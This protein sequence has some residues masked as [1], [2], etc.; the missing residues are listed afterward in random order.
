MQGFFSKLQTASIVRPDGRKVSC[1]S[2][3][4]YKNPH[5]PKMTPYGNFEKGIM[6]IGEYPSETDDVRGK[7]FQGKGGRLLKET[8]A[9][10]GFDLFN[11][12]VSL[13]AINCRPLGKDGKLAKVKPFEIECC[14]RIVLA[15][16]NKYK[17]KVIILLGGDAVRSVIGNR[18]KKDLGKI[19]KWRGWTIPDQDLKTWIC[20]VFSADFVELS[21]SGKTAKPEVLNVWKQDLG[22]ALG[23]VNELDFPLYKEPN[24]HYIDETRLDV[25]DS[26]KSGKIAF[27]YEATGLKP[28]QKGHK[29]VC[30]SIATSFDDVYTFMMP[31]KRS[32]KQPFIRLMEDENVKKISHNMKYERGWTLNILGTNVKNWFMDTMLA[33][34]LLDNRTGVTGLKFQTY[35]QFGVASYDD[36]IVSYL[37]G[38]DPKNANSF[39]T[40]L[41][42]SKTKE[43][44]KELLHYCALDSIFTMRLHLL[45]KKQLDEM[46]IPF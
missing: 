46:S 37:K 32:L 16:I 13:N 33:A 31:A 43:G 3:G 23:C 38:K 5:S 39:N 24:I 6:C 7:P 14:R 22:K 27:D 15:A 8:F 20:P 2:C 30:A 29:I 44:K 41:E 25:L 28:H 36:S 18:W 12:C 42:L 9:E 40:I 34:H 1:N 17:P 45:Q 4:L 21:Q 35:V 19:D 10:L 26:I 11:D